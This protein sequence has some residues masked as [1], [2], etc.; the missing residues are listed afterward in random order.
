MKSSKPTSCSII[1]H[2]VCMCL[3]PPTP[4]LNIAQTTT[5]NRIYVCLI[6][7][8]SQASLI[9]VHHAHTAHAIH[10]HFGLS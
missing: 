10:V 7:M 5:I 6:Y 2:T 8:L 1:I 4:P 3:T 9:C